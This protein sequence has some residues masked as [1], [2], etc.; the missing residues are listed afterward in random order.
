M[1]SDF[2]K[3]GICGSEKLEKISKAAQIRTFAVGGIFED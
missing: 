1:P 3:D 2:E